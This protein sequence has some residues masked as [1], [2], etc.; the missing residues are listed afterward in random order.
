MFQPDMEAVADAAAL[1]GWSGVPVGIRM[2]GSDAW[3]IA[4]FTA[5]SGEGAATG[6]SIAIAG[7]LVTGD[8]RSK[9]AARASVFAGYCPRA[10]LVPDGRDVLSL[11]MEAAVL[12]QGV[13]VAGETGRRKLSDAGP[14]VVGPAGTNAAA[15]RDFAER[16]HSR[17]LQATRSNA[18]ER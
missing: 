15:Q 11:Q 18:L 6:P 12:D 3:A 14:T 9:P 16:V 2:C 8:A 4:S 1:L 13:V 17:L 10:I 5:S 7:V